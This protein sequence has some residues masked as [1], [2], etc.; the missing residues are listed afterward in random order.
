MVKICHITTVHPNRYDVRIFEKECVTLAKNGYEVTLIVN[1][2]LQDEQCKGVKIVS[3]RINAKNRVD[4]AI[5]VAQEAFSKAEKVNA[6]IYHI[7]DPELLGIAVKLKKNGK[8]VIFDSHE[9]TAMQIL[10]KEY[11][12]VLIRK[13]MSDI[14]RYYEENRIKKLSGLVMP[15]L[16]DGKDYFSKVQ[17]PKVI[18]GNMP[19]IN[20]IGDLCKTYEKKDKVCYVGSITESRGIF[21]MIKAAFLAEKKLV[22]IGDMSL[23]MKQM[24]EQMPEYSNVEY[25][26]ALS[27]DVALHE[28]SKCAVGLALL[29][30]EGQYSK[31]GNLPTKLYEYMMLGIPA[32]ISNFS[33]YEKML[34]KYEFGIACDPSNDLAIANAINT[35]IS[36]DEK[37]QLMSEMGRKAIQMELNWE[38]DAKKLLEFYET[39]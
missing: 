33:F 2:K 34:K 11:I 28:M 20:Q 13:Q 16:Y 9:F 18:I 39:L 25:L 5:R 38:Q 15:C 12:P 30:D 3:L 17:I 22:L 6:E 14:Y 31:L 24:L 7:H 19:I 23:E 4:R 32:V 27:H 21:H 1:D 29:Q 36:N 10:T 37:R 35:I 26:G 8:K